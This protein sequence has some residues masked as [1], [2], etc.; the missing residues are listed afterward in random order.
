MRALC[1]PRCVTLAGQTSLAELPV[2]YAFDADGDERFRAGPFL[3]NHPGCRV[4]VLF[5]PETPRLYGRW[6]IARNFRRAGLLAL[7]QRG[8]SSEDALHGQCLHAGDRGR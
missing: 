2:L 6:A 1:G 4:F 5:G 3:R 7:R 8:Q